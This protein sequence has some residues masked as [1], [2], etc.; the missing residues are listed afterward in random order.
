[1]QHVMQRKSNLVLRVQCQLQASRISSV[2]P[3]CRWLPPHHLSSPLSSDRVMVVVWGKGEIIIRAAQFYIVYE[4][5]SQR[6]V[7]THKCEQFLNQNLVRF[8]LIFACF[9]IGLVCIFVLAQITLVFFCLSFV[10][11]SFFNNKSR[12]WLG[13]TF[14]K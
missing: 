4:S 12:D 9:C 14:Q 10:A 6:Y 3:P 13:R 8:R 2:S 7:Y 5:C 1:M 11:F